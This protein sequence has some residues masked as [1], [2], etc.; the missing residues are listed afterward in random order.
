MAKNENVAIFNPLVLPLPNWHP[1][2]PDGDLDGYRIPFVMPAPADGHDPNR[3]AR[4]FV[5]RDDDSTRW[6]A[7]LSNVYMSGSMVRTA[8]QA[9]A[10][11]GAWLRAAE[12]LENVGAAD[13]TGPSE[14]LVEDGVVD[15]EVVDDEGDKCTSTS[16]A[17]RECVWSAGHD[18]I[19][20]SADGWTWRQDG[21]RAY[22]P[23]DDDGITENGNWTRDK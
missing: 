8:E 5:R 17:G 7:A 6:S 22:L 4:V 3:H 18:D 1:D 12:V 9:R 21:D 23:G 13:P 11:A 15:A 14:V 10:L 20:F 19:H 16:S 2:G